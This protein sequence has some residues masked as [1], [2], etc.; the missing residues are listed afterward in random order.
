[1]KTE[2][3]SAEQ[4]ANPRETPGYL[5]N[6]P[7][8]GGKVR[9]NTILGTTAY[10]CDGCKA[11]VKFRETGLHVDEQ[12]KRFNQRA[13]PFCDYCKETDCACSL[14]ESCSMIRNYL[15]WRELYTSITCLFAEGVEFM[16]KAQIYDAIKKDWQKTL[17]VFAGR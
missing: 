12:E 6:C 14:D 5:L 3:Q 1:M 10:F 16:D 8:C 7:F 4:V 9:A 11:E 15:K 13:N 2:T 17:P